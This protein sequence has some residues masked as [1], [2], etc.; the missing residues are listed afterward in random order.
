MR[1]LLAITCLLLLGVLSAHGK[2]LKPLFNYATFQSDDGQPYLE[3][4]LS[5]IGSSVLFDEVK[6]NHFQGA[7][8]VTMSIKRNDSIFFADRILLK[9]P[10]VQDT[11]RA[12]E[13]FMHLE[14]VALNNGTYE[15]FLS[16]SDAQRPEKIF[17]TSIPI[18][19]NYNRSE[20][21][22]SD[23]NLIQSYQATTENNITSKAG[24]DM[25]IDI[26]Y[27]DYFI[28]KEQEKITFYAE[29][30]NMDKALNDLALLQ[31]YIESA[32]TKFKLEESKRVK[33]I[34]PK[35]V[36]PFLS[37][38][39][40]ANLPSGNYNL[41]LE[42]YDRENN[43]RASKK[44]LFERDNPNAE[45]NLAN[46]EVLSPENTFASLYTNLDELDYYIRSLSP[47]SFPTDRRAAK[48]V[49]EAR[50]LEQMQQ[51]LYG[52]WLNRNYYEPATAWFAYLS[53]VKVAEEMF[54]TPQRNGFATD[55]GRVFLKYGRPDDVQSADFEP[56]AYP[57]Q[58][59]QYYSS[60][61]YGK[62]NLI[63]VFLNEN[64]ALDEYLLIH[65]NALGEPYDASW[66]LRVFNR[67]NATNDIDE[68][69][70]RDHFGSY[71]NDGNIFGTQGSG[72]G[73]SVGPE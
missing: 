22:I 53:E 51:Y 9:G 60:K 72:S 24:Y 33:K 7:V 34:E 52:F 35:A 28:P 61:N 38:M 64:F 55:R 45:I 48:N 73:G 43:L 32:E 71:I 14:R 40:V 5:I 54:G 67:S 4:Y 21:A 6:N 29:L 27:G 65:S 69:N 10:I 3:T 70:S 59:W 50:N 68:T 57:Y 26:P 16:L 17:D 58:I 56:S 31:F 18:S 63:F 19:I 30:Y 15:L 12:L 39:N 62:S 13:N 44:L 25:L 23:I 49:L 8:N 41:V 11:N 1:K 2:R 37:S 66:K 46:A 47:I 42:L 20:L 36:Q